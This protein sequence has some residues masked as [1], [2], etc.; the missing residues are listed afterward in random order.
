MLDFQFDSTT[1]P[2]NTIV[3]KLLLK[4]ILDLTAI[5]ALYEWLCLRAG[6]QRDVE[7]E[8]DAAAIHFVVHCYS[9]GISAEEDENNMNLHRVLCSLSY[10]SPCWNVHPMTRF[11]GHDSYVLYLFDGPVTMKNVVLVR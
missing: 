4:K 1:S 6:R 5:N 9:P 11:A 2:V 10:S 7:L 8:R 3:L